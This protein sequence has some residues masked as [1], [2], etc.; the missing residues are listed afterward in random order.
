MAGDLRR[1]GMTLA[2][3]LVLGAGVVVV[4]G[5]AQSQPQPKSAPPADGAAPSRTVFQRFV[6]ASLERS[7][8]RPI[9]RLFAGGQYGAAE[10]VLRELA[11]K[12]PQS[13]LYRYNLAAAL[14]RLKK[15]NAAFDSLDAA[16]ALGFSNRAIVEHDPDL[17]SLRDRPQY[18]ALL[19]RL[20][21]AA[22]RAAKAAKTP[23]APAPVEDHVARV[24]EANTS[25]AYGNSVLL[26]RF[27]FAPKPSEATVHRGKEAFAKRLND[28]VRDGKAAGNHGDLYDNRDRG[29]SRFGRNGMR[30][31]TLIEYG[32]A[33]K[34]VGLDYGVNPGLLFNAITFGNSST[35]L[36]HQL[37]WRSQARLILTTPNLIVAVNL[38]YLN[39]HVYVY[40][41]HRDHDNGHGDLLP[42]NTPYMVISQGSSGSDQPFLHAIA[43]ILAALRPDVKATLRH[44]RL[45]MPT[46]QMIL[47]RGQKWVKSDADYM[48]G[49]AH[50]SVF[51]A[52]DIDLPK[53][54]DLANGL[55]LDEVPPPVQ[56]AV[57]AQDK[58]TPGVDFFAPSGMTETLFA[59][60][61]AIARIFRSSR[62]RMRLVVS[63]EKTWDPNGRPL[64]FHWVVLGGD[65]DRISIKPLDDK[66]TKAEISVPWHERHP[67]SP[68]SP[69][70]TDRVDI[71]V[72]A[73]NGKR[74]SAPAFVSFLFPGDQSRTYF[75][76]GR[77]NCIDY[78]RPGFRDRYV[79]PVIFPARDWRD[80]YQYDEHGALIGWNRVQGGS[81]Q[82]FARDGAKVT[83][84]DG[85]GRPVRA[86]RVRYTIEASKSARPKVVPVLLNEFV[87]YSYRDAA[88]RVGVAK[89]EPAR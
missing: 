33:A 57:D 39:N 28:L 78:D 3:G 87:R 73:D 53:L 46:V 85:E 75:A 7:F 49:R 56:L 67:V 22:T 37:V 71:G 42:A 59:T 45:V 14:A 17:D 30:Q 11:G 25:L 9:L 29:H 64:R 35:A 69:L 72:F 20:D 44:S 63:A 52:K 79:D 12:Y 34:A 26:S 66:G 43:V 27:Q 8:M 55:A 32:A 6:D 80:C 54:V 62:Y 81:L 89:P 70:T 86:Q 88:D 60:P 19:A 23:P 5:F 4:A 2:A 31:V 18:P 13:A 24:E 16:I 82:R 48:S 61:G 68:G 15:T 51:S 58:A 65:A 47:R 38:Q 36:N 41:E 84:N 77:I 21:A 40:P 50:P 10:R 76:D 1:W 74:I 83:E